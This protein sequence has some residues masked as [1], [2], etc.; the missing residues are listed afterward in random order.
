MIFVVS[1]LDNLSID[2]I[3]IVI[4]EITLLT[5]ILILSYNNP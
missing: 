1:I 5:L 3:V 2:E 4:V